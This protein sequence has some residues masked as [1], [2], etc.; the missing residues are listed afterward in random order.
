MTCCEPIWYSDALLPD[1]LKKQSEAKLT[2]HIS[3]NHFVPDCPVYWKQR[4]ST[5]IQYYKKSKE[6]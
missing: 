1:L 4:K 3:R 6:A 5:I 2:L